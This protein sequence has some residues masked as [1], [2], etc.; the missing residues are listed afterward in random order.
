LILPPQDIQ[1]QEN[2]NANILNPNSSSIKN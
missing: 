2:R 1:D